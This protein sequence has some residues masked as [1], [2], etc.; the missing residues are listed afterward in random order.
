MEENAGYCVPQKRDWNNYMQRP[1][2][3][4]ATQAHAY[5]SAT[6][7]TALAVAKVPQRRTSR[8]S[9]GVICPN[10]SISS[11]TSAER[12]TAIFQLY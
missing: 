8:K 6:M 10:R 7:K 9:V 12:L 5:S 2:S 1:N 11:E 4:M 3:V